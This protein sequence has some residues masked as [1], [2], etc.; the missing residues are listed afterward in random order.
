MTHKEKVTDPAHQ[1][2]QTTFLWMSKIWVGK[3]FESAITPHVR[4]HYI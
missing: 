3:T 2:T 4:Y 1:G